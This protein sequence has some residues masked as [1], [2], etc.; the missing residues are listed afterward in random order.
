MT[1]GQVKK[2]QVQIPLG[3]LPINLVLIGNKLEGRV[4]FV[5]VRPVGTIF[6]EPEEKTALHAVFNDDNFAIY[7]QQVGGEIEPFE[8]DTVYDY[9]NIPLMLRWLQQQKLQEPNVV[10]G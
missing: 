10:F 9:K 2:Y 6:D 7:V 3:G 8:Y 1:F 5:K 4:A